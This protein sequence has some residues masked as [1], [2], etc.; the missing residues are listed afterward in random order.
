MNFD[1]ESLRRFALAA[2]CTL[3]GIWDWRLDTQSFY[4]SPRWLE[5]LGRLGEAPPADRDE[6]LELVHPKDRIRLLDDLDAALASGATHFEHEH[7][8]KHAKGG[9]RWA[10][11]RAVIVRS[12]DG[13]AVR[14][15]GVQTDVSDWKHFDALARA[16]SLYDPLTQLAGRRLFDRRLSRALERAKKHSDYGFAVLFI[17]LDRFKEINDGYGHLVGDGVLA[18]VARRLQACLRPGDMIARR[19]GDEFTVLVDDLEHLADADGVAERIRAHVAAPLELCGRRFS[20]STSIG[21]AVSGPGYAS[22]E[23]MIHDA[24]R[25][26]YQAKLLAQSSPQ[27]PSPQQCTPQQCT[28]QLG[29]DIAER[30]D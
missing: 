24:D 6:W 15:T 17:D 1:D 5:M 3:D 22:P 9:Y 8:L 10:A 2:Q 14:M 26:M 16:D 20:V 11:V 27:Q 30:P 13:A 29:R 7:R 25:A 19:G 18:E 12:P 23:E 28:P 4:V 21:I